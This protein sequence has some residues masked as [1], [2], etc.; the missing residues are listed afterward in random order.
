MFKIVETFDSFLGELNV[1][2]PAGVEDKWLASTICSSFFGEVA[3]A[4]RILAPKITLEIICGGLS[5]ELNKMQL[6]KGVDGRP[7]TF[8]RTY[9]RMWLSNVP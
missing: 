3:D 7:D 5:Q 4:L 6:G 8:P 1:K 9:T 2:R